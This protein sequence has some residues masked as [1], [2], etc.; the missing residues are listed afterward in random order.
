M[1]AFKELTKELK[2]GRSKVRIKD[3]SKDR[4]FKNLREN[5]S[6]ES[7]I[8]SQ[9][10]RDGSTLPVYDISLIGALEND[11]AEI[12][13]LYRKILRK[14]RE[15]DLASLQLTL[16]EFST[17][18]THHIQMEDEQFYG[19]LKSMARN[20]SSTEQK[21]V[22]EFYSEMKNIS[23]SIFSFLSQSPYIPVSFDNI[24]Y[25]ISEFKEMGIL[26]EDRITRE[27]TF[28]YPIYKSS[29]KVV[30]IS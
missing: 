24:E 26:L 5:K 7:K 9:L 21:V 10:K 14:A 17:A 28:L 23:I 22:A 15:G 18:F 3:Q 11:H 4:A 29:R 20:K 8:D 27:E 2:K 6:S 16:L 12:L 30:D 25:F 19:Y 13:T 1:S